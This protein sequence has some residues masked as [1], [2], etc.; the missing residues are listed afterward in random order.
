MTRALELEVARAAEYTRMAGVPEHFGM[1]GTT[2]YIDVAGYTM[3][4]GTTEVAWGSPAD[5]VR[6]HAS[7]GCC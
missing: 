1:A 4:I 3:F 2:G 5:A 6:P 7:D